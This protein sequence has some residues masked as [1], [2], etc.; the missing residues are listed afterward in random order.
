MTSVIIAPPTQVAGA[1]RFIS[2]CRLIWAGRRV[3]LSEL[4]QITACWG[5]RRDGTIPSVEA[6]FASS[7]STS[8]EPIEVFL[9]VLYP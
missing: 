4:S 5:L 2:A 7:E 8:A 3:P 6:S 9:G 1:H